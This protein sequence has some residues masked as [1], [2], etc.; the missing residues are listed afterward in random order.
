MKSSPS[1]KPRSHIWQP[2]MGGCASDGMAGS[3]AV[4]L[5]QGQRFTP[6]AVQARQGSA[7]CL[8]AEMLWDGGAAPSSAAH[9]E[10]TAQASPHILCFPLTLSPWEGFPE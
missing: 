3:M 6:A 2:A 1:E 4:T 10:D 9:D 5:S 7:D 8:P